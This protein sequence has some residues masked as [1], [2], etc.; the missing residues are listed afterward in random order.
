VDERGTE[1]EELVGAVLENAQN[2]VPVGLIERTDEGAAVEGALQ[3]VRMAVEV[4]GVEPADRFGNNLVR[5]GDSCEPHGVLLHES[6]CQLAGSAAHI[7]PID[8]NPEVA[9][10]ALPS[11]LARPTGPDRG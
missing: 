7:E 1:L 4:R 2:G 9:A 11:R 6:K 10:P 8:P 5:Y 3:V